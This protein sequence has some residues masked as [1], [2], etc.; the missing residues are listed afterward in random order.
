MKF[1]IAALALLITIP[2]HLSAGKPNVEFGPSGVTFLNVQP[3]TKVAW[4]SL[5]RTHVASHTELRIDRGI[6]V[7]K[8][9]RSA[10]VTRAGADQARSIWAVASVDEDI[11][12]T[13]VV[14][15]YS[16]SP[17]SISVV[18]TAGSGTIAVVS[19][20]VELMYVRP[21]GGAWFISATDGGLGDTDLQQNTVIT[22]S[23]QSMERVQGNPHPPAVTAAGDVILMIDPRSNRTTVMKVTQ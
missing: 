13:A 16:A 8:P 5:T 15:G 4:M 7:A 9:S 6:E 3:G 20:E 12:G 21:K 18:A 17:S 19:P 10:V 1:Q 14:P 2:I 23:L 22:I 11:A